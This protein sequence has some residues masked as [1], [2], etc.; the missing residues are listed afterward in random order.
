MTFYF[1]IIKIYADNQ[2]D[3]QWLSLILTGLGF[4]ISCIWYWMNRGSKL[5]YENWEHHI[6]LIEEEFGLG[7]MSRIHF[8]K[9]F[10]VWEIWITVHQKIGYIVRQLAPLWN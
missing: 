3:S 1:F 9:P 8:Y 2:C 4:V 5:I 10:A 6:D 7:K